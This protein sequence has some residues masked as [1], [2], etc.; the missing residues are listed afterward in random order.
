VKLKA[1]QQKESKS[2]FFIHNISFLLLDVKTTEI[3]DSETLLL[4]STLPQ[5]QST[6]THQYT[7]QKVNNKH[8]TQSSCFNSNIASCTYIHIHLYR[9]KKADEIILLYLHPKSSCHQTPSSYSLKNSS[10][11]PNTSV[12]LPHTSIAYIYAFTHS[13]HQSL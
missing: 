3:S 11:S 12:N 7:N 8:P 4:R 13:H 1:N 6:D 5:V 9:Q 10:P 2:L